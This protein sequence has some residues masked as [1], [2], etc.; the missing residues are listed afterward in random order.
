V[1]AAV[2]ELHGR[3]GVVAQRFGS[4]VGWL[5]TAGVPKTSTGKFDKKVMR[6]RYAE[7]DL[8]ITRLT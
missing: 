6:A 3:H 2:R 4:A 8:D 5:R 1:T 7:A